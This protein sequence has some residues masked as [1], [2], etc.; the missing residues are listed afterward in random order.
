M[1]EARELIAQVERD[2]AHQLKEAQERAHNLEMGGEGLDKELE[3]LRSRLEEEERNGA[4]EE[5]GAFEGFVSAEEKVGEGVGG[6]GR[7]FDIG[8]K[9]RGIHEE[10]KVVKE[11]LEGEMRRKLKVSEQGIV[12]G[13]HKYAVF[14]A[15]GGSYCKANQQTSGSVSCQL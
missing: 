9:L 8:E 4:G 13:V 14:R 15:L 7:G 2:A 12:P 3:D 6:E 1:Q 5:G 11:R 10:L